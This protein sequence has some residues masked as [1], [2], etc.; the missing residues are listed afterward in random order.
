MHSYATPLTTLPELYAKY[1][2]SDKS[3]LENSFKNRAQQTI[4]ELKKLKLWKNHVSPWE[5]IYLQSYGINMDKSAHI[6]ASWRMESIGIMMWALQYIPDWPKIDEEIEPNLI[7]TIELKKIKMFSKWPTIRNKEEL[8]KKRDLI[9]L[10]HWRVRTRQIIERGDPFHKDENMEKIGLTSY[11]DIIRYTAR[12]V[13]EKGDSP[14]IIDD[15]FKFQGK[16]F[17]DLNDTEYQKATSII[18]ERHFAL[19]WLCG[20]APFNNWDDTPTDT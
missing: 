20:K 8:N 7:K 9:E 3:T 4:D 15:D 16:A 5:K 6:S 11:E 1:S 2:E 12:L 10:W 17:R 18:M 19:N 13:K 14:E